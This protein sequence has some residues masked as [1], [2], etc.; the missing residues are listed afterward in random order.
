MLIGIAGYFALVG[1]PDDD[2]ENYGFLSKRE[3]RMIVARV[4]RD[5][6]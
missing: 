4:D 3:K 6:G 5:R 2:R 1:F